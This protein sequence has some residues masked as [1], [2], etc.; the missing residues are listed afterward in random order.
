MFA[1]TVRKLINTDGRLGVIVPTGIATDATCQNFFGDLIQKENLSNLYDFE[2]RKKLFSAIASEIKFTL[3]GISGKAT[4]NTDFS[5]FLTQAKQ[6]ED[7]SRVFQLS[8][9]DIALMNPNTLTCPVFRTKVDA[10]LTKKIYQLVPVLENEKTGN[11]PWGISFMR[12]FDM[13]NDS[14]LFQ[15]S[16]GQGLVP[17]YEGKMFHQF[18]HRFGCYN[19]GMVD[20]DKNTFRAIP[21][22]TI[23]QRQNHDFTIKSRY[24]VDKSE[25]Q[26]RLASKWNKE[27]ILSFRN[28][29]R[30]VDERTAIFSLLPK[31]GVGNSAP[32][33]ILAVD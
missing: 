8:P 9:K 16:A 21:T 4:Q 2:N 12:M 1:E 29:C 32:V 19:Q 15:N 23:E 22:P 18:D 14:H 20:G 5:F 24:W 13:S 17:L 3:L 28:I 30:S 10:E 11:N 31:V 33:M 6:I 27:W 25:V 26:N 7:K